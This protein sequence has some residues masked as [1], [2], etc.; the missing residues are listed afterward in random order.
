[1]SSTPLLA[2]SGSLPGLNVLQDHP[3]FLRISHSPWGCI[4]QNA[5]VLLRGAM[6]TYLAATAAMIGH[7]KLTEESEDSQ[8]RHFFDFPLISYGLVTLYHL[9]TFSWTYTHLYYPDADGV[10]GGIE[11]WV[12]RAMSLPRNMG[13][14]RKQFYF[15]LF[16]ATTAVFSFMNTAIYWFVTR[17]HEEGGGEFVA[18]P[19]DSSNDFSTLARVASQHAPVRAMDGP[20][21][22]IFG[23]GWYAAYCLVSLYGV[24]SG[25]MILETLFLNSTKRPIAAVGQSL[26]E[27]YPFF[28]MDEEEVGSK[29]AVTAYCIAFVLLSQIMYTLLLGFVGIR[30]GLT[31]TLSDRG[32]VREEL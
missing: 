22:D 16:S 13:S 29:E 17:Q 12:V 10:Q 26:T 27:V 4:P 6:L 20:F 15:T 1:M 19:V 32:G 31:R 23:E 11:S 3:A 9:I 28:W 2:A 5:L 30:E 24:T 8:W 18:L 7:Y 21:S 25:L 14:L